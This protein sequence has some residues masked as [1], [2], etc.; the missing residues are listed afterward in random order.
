M[1]HIHSADNTEGWE[2]L[3]PPGHSESKDMVSSPLLSLT[4]EIS[5]LKSVSC[6]KSFSQS[7][8]SVLLI[9]TRSTLQKGWG[10]LADPPGQ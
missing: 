6:F 1:L 4:V 9:C 5:L 8:G 10:G 7:C 2:L 3:A